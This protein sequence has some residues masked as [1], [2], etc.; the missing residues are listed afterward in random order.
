VAL[1]SVRP[2]EAARLAAWLTGRGARCWRLASDMPLPFPAALRD[3]HRLGADR[4][5][6]AAA[7]WAEQLAPAL[8]VD[9]GTALT[10]DLLDPA[11][12]YL[13]GAILPGPEL[14]LTALAAGTAQLPRAQARW[15]AQPWGTD[16]A[17]ALAAG[18]LWG[19]LAAAEGFAARLRGDWPGAAV[20]LTGGLAPALAERWREGEARLEP[21]WTLRGLAALALHADAVA[22]DGASAWE[23]EGGR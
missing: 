10:V 15:P 5:C 14:A 13:G 21:D 12:C 22:S 6:N 20:I 8:V 4:L 23:D 18:A 19:A 7:A 2:V 17:E 1:A 3:R 16:T 9:A 11:G